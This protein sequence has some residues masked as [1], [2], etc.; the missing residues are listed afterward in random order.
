MRF[1]DAKERRVIRLCERKP[2]RVPRRFIFPL[3]EE[4]GAAFG[5]REC[6]EKRVARAGRGATEVPA[7]PRRPRH[8]LTSDGPRLLAPGENA[9]Q[10]AEE[11]PTDDGAEERRRD[12]NRA[13]HPPRPGAVLSGP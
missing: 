4:R 5:S 9:H 10:L 1:V 3:D 13:L 6:F 8:A 11:P 2:R 7:G 12:R